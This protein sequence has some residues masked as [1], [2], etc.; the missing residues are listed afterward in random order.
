MEV[1]YT[2]AFNSEIIVLIVLLNFAEVLLKLS[3][4]KAKSCMFLM[5]NFFERWN[6]IWKTKCVNE[7][8]PTVRSNT[9]LAVFNT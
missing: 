4:Q 9:S 6:V 7:T 1:C 8:Y 5:K 2:A 3:L